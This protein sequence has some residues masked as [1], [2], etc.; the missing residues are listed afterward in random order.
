MCPARA[1]RAARLIPG[2][3]ESLKCTQRCTS[4]S[5]PTP[6]IVSEASILNGDSKIALLRRIEIVMYGK[7]LRVACAPAQAVG[8]KNKANLANE[9]KTNA[10]SFTVISLS[11]NKRQTLA[12][13]VRIKASRQRL[14]RKYLLVVTAKLS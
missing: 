11:L 12:A 13:S 2:A 7:A 10:A 4:D 5:G 6:S 14:V 9:K 8:T 1:A 3:K